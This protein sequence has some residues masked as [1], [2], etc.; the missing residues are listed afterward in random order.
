MKS[1]WYAADGAA[2]CIDGWFGW[3]VW[4]PTIGGLPRGGAHGHSGGVG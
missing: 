3:L 2:R 4:V 1:I